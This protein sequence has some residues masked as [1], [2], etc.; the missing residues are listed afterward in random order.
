[1]DKL[2][3]NEIKEEL[4]NLFEIGFNDI[5]NIEYDANYEIKIND[6]YYDLYHYIIS[7]QIEINIIPDFLKLKSFYQKNMNKLDFELGCGRDYVMQYCLMNNFNNNFEKID[8]RIDSYIICAWI[9]TFE[10]SIDKI[11]N[12]SKWASN[13]IKNSLNIN[14]CLH[15]MNSSFIIDYDDL[16][17][18][19]NKL[20]ERS[21]EV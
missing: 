2:S 6:V 20:P 7:F 5:V 15:D 14:C 12:H 11:I 19:F 13:L 16:I 17:S 3:P 1:M 21:E 10:E 9:G 8:D 4:W 18:S